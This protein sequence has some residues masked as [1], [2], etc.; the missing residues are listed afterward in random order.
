MF[1]FYSQST[2]VTKFLLSSDYQI[3]YVY[4]HKDSNLIS[5]FTWKYPYTI[6]F[7]TQ[8]KDTTTANILPEN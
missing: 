6:Q 1:G 8:L 2:N 3:S 7:L 5:G 4:T